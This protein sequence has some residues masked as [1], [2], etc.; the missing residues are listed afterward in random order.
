VGRP[1]WR[2]CHSF[3]Y[4][5]SV[6]PLHLLAMVL[7][8]S[9]GSVLVV[10]GRACADASPH[11]DHS[12]VYVPF[13]INLGVALRT[14]GANGLLLGG[15]ASGLYLWHGRSLAFLGGYADYLHDFGSGL[16]R[17]SFGP[18]AGAYSVGVDTGPV[19][20][21]GHGAT[22]L[23]A[24]ARAFASLGFVAVYVGESYRSTSRYARWSTELGL[25]LKL[26]MINRTNEHKRWRWGY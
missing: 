25:L 22:E 16:H 7:F 1:L 2:T 14:Q 23:G 9:L 21:L 4:A 24:R 19:L 3:A 17:I 26:P 13:G 12:G 15:E 5:A 20:E 11:F 8:L 6:R 18:E 10:P